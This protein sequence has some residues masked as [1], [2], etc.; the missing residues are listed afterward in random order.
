MWATEG[1]CCDVVIKSSW[2]LCKVGANL[3]TD[4]ERSQARSAPRHAGRALTSRPE[5]QI[6]AKASG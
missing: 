4:L 6:I 3:E 5:P 2:H 1:V